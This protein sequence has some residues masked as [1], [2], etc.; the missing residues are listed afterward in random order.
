LK[1]ISLQRTMME[2]IV[3]WWEEAKKKQL[4]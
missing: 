1:K 4:Q 3:P 2:A